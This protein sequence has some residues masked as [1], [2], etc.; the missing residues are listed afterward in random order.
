LI[1]F[2]VGAMAGFGLAIF[3][4]LMPLPWRPAAVETAP[5][6][7]T[8]GGQGA[9]AF[10]TIGDALL[11]ARDGDVI[12]VHAG[13]Y[14][15]AI[16]LRRRVTLVS[17]QPHGAVLVA[18]PGQRA[19]ASVTV[20]ADGTALRGF[21]VSGDA[22]AGHVG[23]R[24]HTGSIDIDDSLFEGGLEVGV[25]AVG[26]GAQTLVRGSRFVGISGVPVQIGDGA[27]VAL[28]QNLFRAAPGAKGPAVACVSAEGVT[29]DAN[30]FMHFTRAP[31]A[32]ATGSIA[33]DPAF[34]IAAPAAPKGRRR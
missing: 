7:L 13:R 10:Q 25:D 30:T 28:R 9:G 22:G 1:V 34:V 4:P 24:V 2:I 8:V 33:I 14:A 26:R 20:W 5:R 18:P 16:E 6:E 27:I 19:W 29:L 31:V 15:E 23:V 3:Y 11:E 21:R 17:E 12:R 32:T